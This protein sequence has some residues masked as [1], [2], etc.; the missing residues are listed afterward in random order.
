MS[1]SVEVLTIIEFIAFQMIK[2]PKKLK[3]HRR[4][5]EKREKDKKIFGNRKWCKDF[6]YKHNAGTGH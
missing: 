1:T 4:G 3:E 2:K 6:W 5:T